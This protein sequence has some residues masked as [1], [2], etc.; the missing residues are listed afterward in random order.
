MIVSTPL[1]SLRT[2]GAFLVADRLNFTS[3]RR[4]AR[5]RS[6]PTTA[7]FSNKNKPPAGCRG[8]KAGQRFALGISENKGEKLTLGFTKTNELFVGRLAMLGVASSIIGGELRAVAPPRR[9]CRLLQLRPLPFQR[10][11]S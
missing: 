7:L 3:L 6:I 10:A 11:G 2:P 5:S 4:S 9:R 1:S 8:D